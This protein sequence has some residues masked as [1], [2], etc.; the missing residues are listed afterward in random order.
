VT[1]LR[2]R[3][4]RSV[5]EASFTRP[6]AGTKSTTGTSTSSRPPRPQPEAQRRRQRHVRGGNEDHGTMLDAMRNA[7]HRAMRTAMRT[8]VL[9]AMQNRTEQNRVL[10]TEG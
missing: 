7:L 3:R 6:P 10:R 5:M 9:N 4:G 2:R 1:F 8:A